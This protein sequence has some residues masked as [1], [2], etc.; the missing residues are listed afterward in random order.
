MFPI[1]MYACM[2]FFFFCFVTIS[3]RIIFFEQLNACYRG[4][5]KKKN[6]LVGVCPPEGG[7]NLKKLYVDGRIILK[8][9]L[10]KH[11]GSVDGRTGAPL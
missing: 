8:G 2:C 3:N 1:Y 9:I 7:T 5:I 10:H 4:K 6:V 11:D